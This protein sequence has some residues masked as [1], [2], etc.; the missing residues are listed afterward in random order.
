[1]IIRIYE[2]SQEEKVKKVNLNSKRNS[3]NN[4]DRM[5]LILRAYELWVKLKGS[6]L[7]LEICKS[8]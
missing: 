4:T 6:K 7:N 8:E 1:M 5:L 3:Y 2:Q